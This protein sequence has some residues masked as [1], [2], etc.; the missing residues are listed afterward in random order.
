VTVKHLGAPCTLGEMQIMAG[1]SFIE[2]ART[3]SDTRL[4]Q[5]EASALKEFLRL[6]PAATL[7]LFADIC[8]R[9]C[10]AARNERAV[11]F[12]VPVRLAALL[13]SYAD[14]FGVATKE[15]TVI[16]YPLT[17][18]DLAA[19]LGI[20][21]RSVRRVLSSW[22]RSGWLTTH[23]GWFV[24]TD[25]MHL[26]DLSTKLRFSINYRLGMSLAELASD[27]TNPGQKAR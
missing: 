24:V 19:G 14:E 23:K 1:L 21:D 5:L 12:D 17:Q 22:K 16:R 20:A 11:L 18:E 10:V 25:K 6:D 8:T 3:M 15:G 26:D 9:F 7:T 13:L 27:P 2:N 4:I